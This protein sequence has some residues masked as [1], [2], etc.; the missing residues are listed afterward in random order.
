MN[1]SGSL[2][3][4][5]RLRSGTS[6]RRAR[7]RPEDA[8][9]S[10]QP[11]FSLLLGL[12]LLVIILQATILRPLSFHGAHVSLVT[13]LIVW[14]GLRAGSTTGGWL[15]VLSGLIEDALGGGGANVI[16]TTLVG[17]IAG[18]LSVRFFADSLPVFVTAVA[19]A[20]W[21]RGL[22]AYLVMEIGLGERGMFHRLS[23]ELVWQTLMN[24]AVAVVALLV[25]RVLSH[26]PPKSDTR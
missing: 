25:L 21:L 5:E 9:I 1:V 10:V 8:E 20:T 16:G 11:N 22:V 15:G 3:T 18:L 26:L 4:P 2:E 19:A 12:A 14:T 13:V 17:Y 23:H 6:A 7:V 24:C